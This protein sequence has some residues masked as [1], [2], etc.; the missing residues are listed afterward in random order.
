[1]LAKPAH[2]RMAGLGESG[3]DEKD[4]ID[5]ALADVVKR[6]SITEADARLRGHARGA[7]AAFAKSWRRE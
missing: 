4:D 7:M 5:N 3:G 6:K 2:M 1:M